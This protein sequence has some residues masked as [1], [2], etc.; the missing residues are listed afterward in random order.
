MNTGRNSAYSR[1]G[2]VKAFGIHL[3]YEISSMRCNYYMILS[4]SLLYDKG[5]EFVNQMWE[6][7]IGRAHV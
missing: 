3:S 1:L 2:I 6:K 7:K 4:L 5:G